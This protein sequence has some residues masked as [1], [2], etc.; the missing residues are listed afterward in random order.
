VELKDFYPAHNLSIKQSA[1]WEKTLYQLCLIGDSC[2]EYIKYYKTP[3]KWKT[4][5]LKMVYV[6]KVFKAEKNQ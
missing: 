5:P 4:T 1:E 3:N 6:M 2:R